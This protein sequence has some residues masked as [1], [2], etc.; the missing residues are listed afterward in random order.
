M[1]FLFLQVL[2]STTISSL[3]AP[4]PFRKFLPH[5]STDNVKAV[6][7]G[8]NKN[9][10]KTLCQWKRWQMTQES[11]RRLCSEAS[12]GRPKLHR[13]QREERGTAREGPGGK[14][15]VETPWKGWWRHY[16][17]GQQLGL[18]LHVP[19]AATQRELCWPPAWLPVLLAGNEGLKFWR[20]H[21][22][23]SEDPRQ[24]KWYVRDKLVQTATESTGPGKYKA[25]GGTTR[26]V[27]VE[28]IREKKTL[29]TLQVS[30]GNWDTF[31]LGFITEAWKDFVLPSK[32]T[33]SA[34][35]EAFWG[36]SGTKNT[37]QL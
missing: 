2:N 19:E 28:D 18:Q 17:W 27:S 23:A 15:V 26:N 6:L 30:G 9:R 20:T 29:K 12:W 5:S 31:K 13:R 21:A 25:A 14:I 4:K 22:N 24:T 32:Q 1:L 37:A 11:F 33:L 8:M 36:L 35:T 34:V 16:G 7:R 10:I 3:P